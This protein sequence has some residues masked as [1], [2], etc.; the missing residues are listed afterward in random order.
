MT[1]IKEYYDHGFIV[2]NQGSQYLMID[3]N[4][5]VLLKGPTLIREQTTDGLII[6]STNHVFFQAVNL[7]MEIQED[8]VNHVKNILIN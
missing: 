3:V 1:I 7:F 2:V 4:G 8:A 6:Y 5:E